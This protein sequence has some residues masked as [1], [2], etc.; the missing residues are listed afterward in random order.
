MYMKRQQLESILACGMIAV[1]AAIGIF[2]GVVFF[3]HI[4]ISSMDP[5]AMAVSY[6][7]LMGGIWV[8]L[9]IRNKYF[10]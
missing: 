8:F 1:I 2:F 7:L 3:F 6:G 9:L 10:L 4:E 5:T